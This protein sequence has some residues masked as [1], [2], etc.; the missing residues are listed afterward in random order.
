MSAR[1]AAKRDTDWSAGPI[2]KAAAL[3]E[4]KEFDLFKGR[5]EGGSLPANTTFCK[6]LAVT[7]GR[8][9]RLRITTIRT[10]KGL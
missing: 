10:R 2:L 3:L 5:N 8:T 7:K 4:V 1:T 9:K 6:R